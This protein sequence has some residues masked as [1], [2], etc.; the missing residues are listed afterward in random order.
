MCTDGGQA[1]GLPLLSVYNFILNAYACTICVLLCDPMG[2]KNLVKAF[3]FCLCLCSTATAADITAVQ[4]GNWTTNSTWDLNRAPMD[5]DNV[6][7]PVGKQVFFI[8]VPYPQNNPPA[9]PTLTIRIYGILDFSTPGNDKL[10]LDV[11]SFIQIYA[12]G[13]IQTT[14]TSTE[15]IAIYNGSTD[16]TVWT[17]NPNTVNGAAYATSTTAGF[18]NGILPLTLQSFTIEKINEGKG[19]LEWIS[20]TESN[21]SY[22]S[23]EGFN[24]T[25]WTTAGI[26]QAAGN[27]TVSQY[28][29]YNVNLLKGANQF[30]LKEVDIDGKYSYSRVVSLWND[31]KGTTA[32]EYNQASGML[33]IINRNDSQ[34][35]LQVFD[36]AGRLL[37]KEDLV[38]TDYAIRF[39]PDLPGVYIVNYKS[40][41]GR[42]SRKIFV[43]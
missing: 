38:S 16:N 11:G 12:G 2:M 27:S 29:S 40:D 36:M 4:N 24:G 30:R 28:Y 21:T 34:G 35:Q 6:I 7:I 25:K 8:N 10:Y 23:I 26:V 31:S 20:S 33:S 5:G 15:I 22:F 18:V 39:K 37:K 42:L 32:I 1:K 9:R 19:K 13:K 43:H 3:I 17:G 41:K 14:T